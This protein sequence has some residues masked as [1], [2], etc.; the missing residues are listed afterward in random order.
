MLMDFEMHFKKADLYPKSKYRLYINSYLF[1]TMVTTSKSEEECIELLFHKVK[2][3]NSIVNIYYKITK[4]N[5]N[6][7]EVL[8]KGKIYP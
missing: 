1:Y 7:D 8:K 2:D 5:N 6:K 3:R 4:V